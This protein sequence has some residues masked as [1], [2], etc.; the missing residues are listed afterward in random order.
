MKKKIQ[1]ENDKW[2]SYITPHNSRSGKIYD[3]TKMHKTDNT[4]RVITS[5]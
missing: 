5:G 1:E 4:A 2:K 3:R